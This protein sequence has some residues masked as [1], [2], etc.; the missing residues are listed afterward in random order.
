MS[1]KTSQRPKAAG[2][3]IGDEI[4]NG[5]V[6]DTNSKT[7]ASFFFKRGIELKRIEIVPDDVRVFCLPARIFPC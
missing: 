1:K 7:L 5:T 2:L 6:T 4:L 3:I